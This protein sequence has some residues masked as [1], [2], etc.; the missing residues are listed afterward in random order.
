MEQYI[1]TWSNWW[2]CIV[3]ANRHYYNELNNFYIINHFLPCLKYMKCQPK[4]K[5]HYSLLIPVPQKWDGP[6]TTMVH[7]PMIFLNPIFVSS[8]V[9]II[10]ML[11]AYWFTVLSLM[12]PHYSIIF[13][14]TSGNL[15]YISRP[16]NLIS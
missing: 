5:Y 13:P 4:L 16:E 3:G 7:L 11:P 9:W 12:Y 8:R 14:F 2:C 1:H 10:I 15:K 6:T